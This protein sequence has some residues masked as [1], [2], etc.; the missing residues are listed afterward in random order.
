MCRAEAI[1]SFIGSARFGFLPSA[2]DE[3]VPVPA[4]RIA[5][6]ESVLGTFILIRREL[7][8]LGRHSRSQGSVGLTLLVTVPLY[9]LATMRRSWI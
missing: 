2:A 5:G 1:V 8:Y 6:V 9:L 4:G 7:H 3:M